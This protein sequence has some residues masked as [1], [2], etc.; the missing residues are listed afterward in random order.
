M[1]KN[2]HNSKAGSIIERSNERITATSEVFTPVELICLL[3][4][5]IPKEILKNPESKFLDNAAG[6][7]NFFVALKEILLQY[8][9]E[10]HILNN[11]FYAVEFMEDN[12][13]EM[14]EKLGVSLNHPHYVCAD[15]L[16][17]HYE[18]NGTPSKLS[19]DQFF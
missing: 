19:L 10:E 7:G 6:C 17:Y 11:M 15:A 4:D 1:S 13:K 3:L 2:N 8:H 18:F 16:E 12:H 5:Q 14:C 9:S